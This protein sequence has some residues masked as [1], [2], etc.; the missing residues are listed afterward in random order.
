MSEIE[1]RPEFRSQQG[2]KHT[3]KH[4]SLSLIQWGKAWAKCPF[5]GENA[6]WRNEGDLLNNGCPES[7]WYGCCDARVFRGQVFPG[8]G[9]H[10][11]VTRNATRL[12]KYIDVEDEMLSRPV[13]LQWLFLRHHS[14]SVNLK[15]SE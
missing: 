8:E 1:T 13:P 3:R 12:P 6:V 15:M 9:V 5:A 2:R 4:C 7:K 11:R 14:L 10:K